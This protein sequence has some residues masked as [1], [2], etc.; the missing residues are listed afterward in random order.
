M[1]AHAQLGPSGA[2]RWMACPGS[3]RLS[4]GLPDES[5]PFAEEGTKAHE[6]A[7]ICLKQGYHPSDLPAHLEASDD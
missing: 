6:L 5:S 3:V 7:E 2:S 1:S 4:A